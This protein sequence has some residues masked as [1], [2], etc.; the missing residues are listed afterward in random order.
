MISYKAS[1]S[2]IYDYIFL[3][4]WYVY[5]KNCHN[6]HDNLFNF[7]SLSFVCISFMM[8]NTINKSIN[9]QN[10]VLKIHHVSACA[11]ILTLCK[12]SYCT[13]KVWEFYVYDVCSH[14]III[15]TK[16][17]I[18]YK[19]ISVNSH[20]ESLPH[21]WFVTFSYTVMCRDGGFEYFKRL[22]TQRMTVRRKISYKTFQ[23]TA[24][25]VNVRFKNDENK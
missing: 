3:C 7:H 16:I 24:I 10:F 17:I 11:I 6:L 23:S 9:K 20:T 22:S 1:H 14:N 5:S 19:T 25:I 13:G 2:K 4:I 18:F 15:N 8:I 21:S 12:S